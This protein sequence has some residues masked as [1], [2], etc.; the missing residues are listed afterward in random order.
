MEW[1]HLWEESDQVKLNFWFFF[2]QKTTTLITLSYLTM[3]HKRAVA[4]VRGVLIV[5][6][7]NKPDFE[8]MPLTV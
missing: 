3:A 7:L 2:G 5:V 1:H 8:E 4:P 6:W